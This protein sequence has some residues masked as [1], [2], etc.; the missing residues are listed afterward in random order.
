[1]TRRSVDSA[2][3]SRE[4]I[5]NDL[6][7]DVQLLQKL[8]ELKHISRQNPV[9][10]GSRKELVGEHSWY[11]A[12]AVIL[13][14]RYSPVP[15]DAGRAVLLAVVH[16]VV[17]AFVGDTFAFGSGVVDQKE[18]EERGM[19]AMRQTFSD[20]HAAAELADLWDEYEAQATPEA[21][22]VK[23]LD[24]FVPI[25]LNFTAIESSS[26]KEHGV[27][28][29]KVLKRLGRVEEHIGGLADINKAMIANAKSGGY[30]K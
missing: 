1:M 15:I 23:G 5:A 14:A 25:L 10:D 21:K 12:L 30:L 28:A 24:A 18:R 27:E 16:D 9:G 4:A 20:C 7:R 26:W 19:A 11:I 13:L 29:E 6:P 22:F 8:E 17:E 3:A 2:G